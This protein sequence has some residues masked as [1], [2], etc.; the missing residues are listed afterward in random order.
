MASDASPKCVCKQE[1]RRR[2]SAGM[3]HLQKKTLRINNVYDQN[4]KDDG[5]YVICLIASF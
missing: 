2:N 3:S 4:L 5:M 1:K